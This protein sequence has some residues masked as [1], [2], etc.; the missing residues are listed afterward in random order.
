MSTVTEAER[1]TLVRL[2]TKIQEQ[3]AALSPKRDAAP[4]AS[5]G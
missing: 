4:A 5:I 2:L 3:A 1:K